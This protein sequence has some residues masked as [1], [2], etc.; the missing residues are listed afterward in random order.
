MEKLK[1]DKEN[2]RKF[3]I[4]M[5]IA[6]FVITLLIVI[7]HKHNI[8]PTFI[9]SAIFFIMAFSAPALLKLIY[10]FWM[11]LAFI[12]G[13][14]NT[15]IILI[16]LFY[17]IFTPIGLGMRLFG[18]DLLDRRIEKNKETYWRKKEKREFNRLDY[19]RQF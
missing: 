16:T 18:R 11:R 13:W 8:L 4:T 15:R 7:R 17:L 3:G 12:L 14:I 5:G 1:L 19:E 10:I 9:I 6:F 2:L